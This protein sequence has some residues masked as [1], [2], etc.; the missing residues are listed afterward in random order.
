MVELGV[1][2]IIVSGHTH[3]GAMASL[4]DRETLQRLP[5]VAGF[6]LYADQ[7][8]R[9]LKAKYPRLEGDERITRLVKEN[10]LIQ[11]NHLRSLSSVSTAI[12]RG[13]L[14]IHGWVFMI[15]T[16]EVLVYDAA[17]KQ[18]IPVENWLRGRS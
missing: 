6:L 9:N 10:V 15:E 5:A 17:S 8:R 1:K 3:C 12:R 11:L 16:G 4:L 2:H 14:Q 13:E 18:F 7:L